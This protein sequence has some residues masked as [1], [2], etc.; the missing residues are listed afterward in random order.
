M[1]PVIRASL[2]WHAL[3]AGGA[4]ASP[5]HWPWWL[6]GV[7]ANQAL[8]TGAGL[9]PR[10]AL[11]GPNLRRLPQAAA[12]RGEIALTI[13]DGPDPQVTPRV[14]DLLQ[15]FGARA[16]FFCIGERLQQHAAL[17]RTIVTQG[18]AIENHSQHHRHTFAMLGRGGFRRE[19]A[20]AQQTI[21]DIAGVAPRFFRAPAGLR[22]PLLQPVLAEL[23]LGLT[24][25]TRRGF[26]TV[27][28]D[29]GR[30][31]HRLE[32]GLAAGDILLLHDGHAACGADGQPVI[33]AVL[34]QLLQRIQALDLR[35]V[36]LRE[37]MA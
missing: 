6:A 2:A 30:V 20:A 1:K 23:G 31:L 12:R 27:T 36:T 35:T 14:L 32:Q 9:L 25:W 10:C 18:H 29:A 16:T 3:M 34:P 28:A 11:L 22:N 26:D 13:D 24:S 15:R 5:G 7:G 4:I 19:I 37:A 33:L 17:A 8:L 21:T